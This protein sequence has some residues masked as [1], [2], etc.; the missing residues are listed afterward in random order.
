MMST[1]QP[2][3]V[4]LMTPSINFV[5][6]TVTITTTALFPVSSFCQM[7]LA[8]CCQITQLNYGICVRYEL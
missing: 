4:L 7:S 3:T 1:L 5:Y 6:S 8:S 2:S